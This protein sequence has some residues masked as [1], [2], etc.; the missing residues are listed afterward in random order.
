MILI[1]LGANLPHPEH[2]P[3]RRTLEA[4]LA[5]LEAADVAVVRCSPWFETPPWPPS[6]QPWYANGVAVLETD[7]EPPALLS[8][9]HGVERD[10]GRVRGARNEARILDL[11]LL[12][13]DGRV[14][15]GQA[16]PQLPHPRLAE[17]GFVLLPLQTVAPGWHHPVSGLS[18][19]A[20][21]ARLPEAERAVRP[22]A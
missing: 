1:A 5:A 3:P 20:L 18:V 11:D 2:G 19:E 12:D 9:L 10:F 14:S 6:D 7:L 21:I 13:Y 17:R 22:L 15:E 8:L 4:A 16:P